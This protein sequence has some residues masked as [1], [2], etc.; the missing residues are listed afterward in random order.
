MAP[1]WIALG[2]ACALDVVGG[3]LIFAVDHG[4]QLLVAAR[5]TYGALQSPTVQVV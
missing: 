1:L 5:S 2:V 4:G 3:A